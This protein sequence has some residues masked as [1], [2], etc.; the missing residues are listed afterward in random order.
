[1]TSLSQVSK[2]YFN[3][4]V[5]EEILEY[6][7]GRW[8]AAYYSDSVFRRYVGRKPLTLNT[9]DDW[10]FIT[11]FKGNSLRTVYASAKVYR[12]LVCREDLYDSSNVVMCT[13][14]WD[15]DN[16]LERWE[17]TL[18]AAETIVGF[19][20]DMGVKRS[21][22]VKWSGRGCHVHVNEKSLSRELASRLSPFDL[23]YAVVEYVIL[24]T[25]PVLAELAE[26]CPSLKVEN[27]MD[28]QRVFTCP[29]SLHRRLDVVCV[30]IDPSKLGSFSLEWTRPGEYR[31]YRG[32]RGFREGELDELAEKAFTVVGPY[33]VRRRRVRKHPPLDKQILD[34]VR[35]LKRL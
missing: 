30:C 15:I 21:V 6:A 28:P 13:P 12:R 25:A 35:R 20:R 24:K 2:H 5:V 33:P 10:R 29:L 19:L 16:D 11:A 1:L 8:V 4:E 18:E 32:W 3:P 27:L 23:A 34:T 17:T 9:P 26:R 14:S 7:R 22:Y 31:H